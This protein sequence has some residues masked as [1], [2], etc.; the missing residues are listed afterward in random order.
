MY[1]YANYFK[2]EAVYLITYQNKKYSC[3]LDLGFEQIRGKWKILI[4]SH[5]DEGPKRFMTLKRL[6]GGISQ[7][8][9]NETLREMEREG[10]IHKQ[11]FQETP[12]RVEYSLTSKG[13]ELIP[14]LTIIETWAERNYAE[15]LE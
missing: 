6:T 2:A 13:Q 4:L 10:I 8:V 5:L 12:P 15:I 7:K 11:V 3:A 9:L 1:I 14:A